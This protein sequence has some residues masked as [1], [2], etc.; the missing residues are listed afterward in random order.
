MGGSH[1]THGYYRICKEK[2]QIEVSSNFNTGSELVLEYISDG[3]TDDGSY[4]LHIYAEEALRAYIWW[5]YIQRKRN[6][7]GQDR[8]LARRDWYNEK[9]LAIARFNT[10]NKEEALNASRKNFRQSPR[11]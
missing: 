11:L 1:N 8:E 9:R 2:N 7:S 10:F 3:S 6:T 4:E 5:K